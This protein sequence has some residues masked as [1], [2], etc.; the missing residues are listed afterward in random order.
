M[1]L[2]KLYDITLDLDEETIVYASDPKFVKEAWHTVQD[3]G[4]LLHKITMGTHAGTHIDAPSHML[5][6]TDDVSDIPLNNF[7]GD[8]ILCDNVEQFD[9]DFSRLLIRGKVN[10]GEAMRLAASKMRLIGTSEQSIGCDEVHKI[11]LRSGCI[12]V[13]SLKLEKV[14]NG[15]YFYVGLPLKMKVDGSPIRACLIEWSCDE[16]K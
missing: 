11:L 16:G 7:I 1:N 3:D 8:C 12:I 2:M 5:E 15:K 14:P 9:Y 6:N 10:K 13:E 4:F